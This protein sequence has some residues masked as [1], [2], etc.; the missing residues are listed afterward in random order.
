MLGEA[1]HIF[2]HDG[3]RTK[4]AGKAQHLGD[5]TVAL[6][7]LLPGAVARA[8]RRKPL[9]RRTAGQQ[10]QLS[11]FQVQTLSKRLGLNRTNV[12]VTDLHF[13]VVCFV[14]FNC[15]RVAL[16]RSEHLEA[17]QFQAKRQTS[18]TGK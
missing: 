17:S 5:E 6:I 3:F 4:R 9:A 16:N 10:V 8:Q 11:H 15:E 18:A 7:S 2:H 14:S 1:R 12:T 13:W